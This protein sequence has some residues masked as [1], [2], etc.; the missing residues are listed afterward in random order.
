[1]LTVC[2]II[3]DIYYLWTAILNYFKNKNNHHDDERFGTLPSDPRGLIEKYLKKEFFE[4]TQPLYIPLLA[5][6]HMPLNFL[7]LN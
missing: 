4:L 5:I 6:L 7:I 2:A 3:I 1:L